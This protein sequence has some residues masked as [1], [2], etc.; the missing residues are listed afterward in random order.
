MPDS[1]A[2][3]TPGQL[4]LSECDREP[5]HILGRVQKFGCL[6]ALSQDWV[7]THASANCADVIGY[8][9]ETLLGVE[10]ER[11]LPLNTLHFFRTRAQIMKL[12]NSSA[13][14][15][16]Y[17]LFDDERS[18]DVS[19]SQSG[20]HLILECEPRNRRVR[21]EDNEATV[22]A[23]IKRV[24]RHR[25]VVAMASEATRAL[26]ALCGFN[27]VMA[28]RFNE[29][30]TG[31]VIA[32]E[33]DPGMEPFLGLR[34]PASD[35]PK[36]AR[37]LY[38]SNPF[39]IIS[40]VS[41][42]TYTILSAG[43]SNKSPLDL[44]FAVT[45]AV[46]PV[47][48]EF[49]SNMGVAA[50]MS[51]SILRG[52]KLWGLFACHHNTARHLNQ[53]IRAAAELFV[54]LFN[55]ELA[56]VEMGLE[57]ADTGRGRMLHDELT[58]SL[59]SGYK[60]SDILSGFSDSIN[61]VIPF[62]GAAI[63]A[64]GKIR[65]VGL[66]PNRQ[67]FLQL[68]QFLKTKQIGQI[69]HSNSLWSDYPAAE[70][71]GDKIAGILALPVSRVARDYL[72]LFRR[73]I[74]QTVTWAGNPDKP[75]SLSDGGNRLSP[76]KSFEAWKQ[77]VRGQCTPWRAGELRAAD[78]LR[79]TLIEVVLK[80]GDEQVA[81]RKKAQ[82][83]QELLIAE[84][85]HRVRNILN[86]IRGL[87]SQG[88]GETEAVKTYRSVLD[89]RIFALA[90]AHDLIS[91]K[92]GKWVPLRGLLETEITAFANPNTPRVQM[93]GDEIDLSPTAFTT[94]ALVIHELVTNS[95]KYGALKSPKGVV[96]LS[97]TTQPN[98]TA[99]LAW[100]E[101]NGPLVQAPT[102]RGF[103]STIIE[104]SIPYELKGRAELRFPET[105]VQANFVLPSDSFR[106]S[107]NR[108]NTLTSSPSPVANNVELSGHCLVLEDNMVIALD[109][110][111]ML[112]ELGAEHVSTAS[113]VSEALEILATS[114]VCFALIDVNLGTENA[115]PVVQKCVD[116]G[117]PA[118]LATG[119]EF[120]SELMA[121]Y[122]AIGLVKK[123][124]NIENLRVVLA[125]PG[126]G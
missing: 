111:D 76:R 60:I 26:K 57:Q 33:L 115:L 75:V 59:S 114:T 24:R 98:G 37:Q 54:Q 55:Y 49:L 125:E 53:E 66:A 116:L 31:T 110:A 8:E 22:Q 124:F 3:A 126:E 73:E 96:S 63:Y 51:V 122:P 50:S 120:D 19:I 91:V 84:L 118:V 14:V 74:A 6:I 86:L 34:Y 70:Q 100:Q 10:L 27:R 93:S 17:A 38:V 113:D 81:I 36:Q 44:S 112:T 13:R 21:F 25:D 9:A 43:G 28:Y 1:D 88:T 104:H 5:I 67:E 48:L 29:D 105:G 61:S 15:T 16:S 80:L 47:H 32:E 101:R 65:S 92:E 18:F 69:F 108:S 119:Y 82:D 46:A 83:Q 30:E 85:N 62:D 121:Q 97:V 90:R 2:S 109:A 68:I 58:S 89:A 23:L 117:I 78:A 4:D 20:A 72:V 11:V 77:T 71:F 56:L 87:V 12:Q 106:A 45:R 35:I 123:P 42:P 79:A 39:R 7:I 95:A 99:E 64:E 41:A 52:E 40:D 107:Q 103:G 102:G 94:L